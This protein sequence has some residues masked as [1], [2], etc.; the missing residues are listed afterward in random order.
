MRVQSF[1]TEFSELVL[2]ASRA[3]CGEV[4][5]LA[6]LRFHLERM[7]EPE[8]VVRTLARALR[9]RQARQIR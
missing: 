8:V 3:R 9:I 4:S 2:L 6:E 7:E 5:A 1:G